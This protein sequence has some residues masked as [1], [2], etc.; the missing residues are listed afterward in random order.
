MKWLTRWTARKRDT[1]T[2]SQRARKNLLGRINAEI[3]QGLNWRQGALDYVSAEMAKH[4]PEFI[5]QYLLSKPFA[6]VPPPK[7]EAPR[8]GG[9]ALVENC[10]YM[11]N[12]LNMVALTDLPGGSRVLDVACGSGWVTQFF[13]RM[14]YPAYGFDISEE[15]V[16]LARRRLSEDVLLADLRPTLGE[17]LFAL[18]IESEP[19][20]AALQGSFDAIVLE[21]CLHHF[22]DPISALENLAAG[23]A[24]DGLMVIIEGEN[25]TGPLRPEYISVMREFSTLERPYARSELEEMLDLVGLTQR[26]F[27]GRVNGWF[28]PRDPRVAALPE[29]VQ[30]DALG[31]NFAIASRSE[32]ALQRIMPFRAHLPEQGATA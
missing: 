31:I 2:E 16:E 7:P 28:S 5:T 12:F 29:I 15:M 20:P 4:S 27:V 24:E 13:S 19:L 32:A 23:L 17:R 10:A 8:S 18:D 26:E 9:P 21:S 6:P 14:G 11:A 1:E 30:G 3:P 22:V 25:R